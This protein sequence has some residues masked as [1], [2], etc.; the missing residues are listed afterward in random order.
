MPVFNTTLDW[1]LV[2][3]SNGNNILQRG[4]ET[5]P[6]NGEVHLNLLV[7]EERAG[8]TVLQDEQFEL[9][10]SPSKT[11]SDVPHD[12]LCDDETSPCP[13]APGHSTFIS[14]LGSSLVNFVDATIIPLTGT[15]YIG[16]SVDGRMQNTTCALKN[17]DVCLMRV[18]GSS[19][20][21]DND[22]Q[23]ECT[24]TG[25]FSLCTFILHQC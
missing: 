23:L 15:L 20:D 7:T 9:R 22:T 16:A 2:N 4:S 10:I 25:K 14:H 12:Y 8:R 19:A 18:T 13:E 17:V 3:N 6:R 5:T 11:S 1:E 21:E 24:E